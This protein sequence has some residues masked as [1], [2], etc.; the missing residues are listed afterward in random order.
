MKVLVV[1]EFYPRR[2]DP[3]L[4]I[5]AH[6]QALAAK[7]AGAEVEV[8]VLHRPIPASRS[9]LSPKA[10]R[11]ALGQPKRAVIDDIDVTYVRYPSPPRPRG[12]GNWG[13]WATPF[14]LLGFGV[15]FGALLGR[16]QPMVFGE[17]T[18]KRLPR[19]PALLPLFA[20]LGLVFMLGIYIPRYLADW[21]REAARLIG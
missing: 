12:Y 16:V 19:A 21:Y 20:H 14:L 5:W 11:A 10:W 9:A 18:A 7:A 8:I 2:S 6:R 3:V 1:S 13:A 4:G 15:A 17:T